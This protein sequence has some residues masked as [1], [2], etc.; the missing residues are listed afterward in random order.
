[1]GVSAFLLVLSALGQVFQNPKK[2]VGNTIS[3][4]LLVST[5]A[6]RYLAYKPIAKVFKAR[7]IKPD[8]EAKA[9]YSISLWNTICLTL[10][11]C[12]VLIKLSVEEEEEEL[13]KK[14]KN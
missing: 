12:C 14:K 1:M 3:L 13:S 11:I 9:L 8:E 10:L 7:Y 4:L 6:I 5:T 2:R